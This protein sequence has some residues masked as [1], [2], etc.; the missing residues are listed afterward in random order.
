[1]FSWACLRTVQDKYPGM[2]PEVPTDCSLTIRAWEPSRPGR[3][4]KMVATQYFLTA[5]TR[6]DGVRMSTV[7]LAGHFSACERVE[8]EVW[9]FDGTEVVLLLDHVMYK[10]YQ[11]TEWDWQGI[12]QVQHQNGPFGIA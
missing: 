3:E 8:F 2:Q 9:S 5:P 1:M 10:V 11:V 7:N 12:G 4:P 6:E